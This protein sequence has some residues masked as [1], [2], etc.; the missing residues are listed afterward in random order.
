MLIPVFFLWNRF[1]VTESRVLIKEIGSYLPFL[2]L[3][4]A[5]LILRSQVI[6]AFTSPI[7]SANFLTRLYFVPHIIASDFLLA[8]LPFGLHSFYV[9]YP[10]SYFGYQTII[11]YIFLLL[12]V[13][14]LWKLRNK[15]LLI[16]SI[17]VFVVTMF[18]VLNLIP[19]ASPSIITMRWL[20]FPLAFLSIAVAYSIQIL[21]SHKSTKFIALSVIS[22]IFL[23][24]AAY[25]YTL[26]DTLWKNQRSFLNIE[27]LQF[28][29]VLFAD[30]LAEALH[31]EHKYRESE[32]LY[33]SSLKSFPGKADIYIN[34]SA[35]LI[36]TGR[37]EEAKKYL[38]QAQALIMSTSKRCEWLNNM[39]VACG[40]LNE[41]Q[42]ALENLSLAVQ[43]CPNNSGFKANLEIIKASN[44]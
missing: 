22:I 30:T 4:L 44:P 25:S 10:E 1:T 13:I 29:N 42:C 20:Y 27:V 35:L 3:G 33:L 12:L 18:P 23:Y 37:P 28:H 2:F 31:S 7:V 24:F 15:R 26:N 39:G 21:T 32:K 14:A 38:N 41:K 36:D 17:S 40:R 5:Y 9:T 8:F 11:S 19:F 6:G 16:F 34:Y 43:Y